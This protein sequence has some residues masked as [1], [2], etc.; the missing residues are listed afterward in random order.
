M[1]AR[2]RSNGRHGAGSIRR[3]RL[4]PVYVSRQSASVPPTRTASSAATPNRFGAPPD[5]NRARRARGDDT[6]AGAFETELAGDDVDRR[7]R[8]VI[9]EIRAASSAKALGDPGAIE[10]LVP[11]QIGRACT[12]EHAHPRSI[13]ADLSSMSSTPASA[14]AS[15]AARRPIRSLRDRR[16]RSSGVGPFID[17]VDVDFGGDPA[18]VARGVEQRG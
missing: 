16:R 3:S 1:P 14:S 11:E 7:T 6:G 8:K 5:R 10:L 13:D 12:Q 2:L 4:K 9:P 15:E 17:R 18:A